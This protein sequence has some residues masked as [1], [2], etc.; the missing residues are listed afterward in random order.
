MR[1]LSCTSKLKCIRSVIA[2]SVENTLSFGSAFLRVNS[3]S[4]LI[5]RFQT[6]SEP[7]VGLSQKTCRMFS[8]F[9]VASC[10]FEPCPGSRNILAGV[11]FH[12]GRHLKNINRMPLFSPNRELIQRLACLTA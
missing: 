2:A 6:A 1:S 11:A 9:E 3:I 10:D 12:W 7:L 5:S 4:A 8:P